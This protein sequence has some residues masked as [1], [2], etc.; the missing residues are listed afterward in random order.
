MVSIIFPSYSL[1][2][3]S[4]GPITCLHQMMTDVAIARR[5]NI[6]ADF[7]VLLEGEFLQNLEVFFV[8]LA[9]ELG[10][11]PG[12]VMGVEGEVHLPEY[13]IERGVYL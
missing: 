7:I 3:L 12:Q 2:I 13:S 9:L 5:R 10:E 6:H 11:V 4:L 8:T 1:V